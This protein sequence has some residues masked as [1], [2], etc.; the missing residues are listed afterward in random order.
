MN[1]TMYVYDTNS[2]IVI[3]EITAADERTVIEYAESHYDLDETCGITSN[4][5]TTT[6]ECESIISNS[7][8]D[9]ISL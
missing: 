7:A 5:P 2:M 8:A 1:T 6:G 3:A 9:I 4:E